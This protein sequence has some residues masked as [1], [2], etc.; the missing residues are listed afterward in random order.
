MAGNPK[1]ILYNKHVEPGGSLL[2]WCVD[3][4][5]TEEVEG[6]TTGDVG[7]EPDPFLTN[8][9]IL[10]ALKSLVVTDINGRQS[11]YT[12]LVDDVVDWESS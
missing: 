12:F 2:H 5:L 8:A 11:T 6:I 7:Y 9:D 10:E 4:R 1:L 3:Y